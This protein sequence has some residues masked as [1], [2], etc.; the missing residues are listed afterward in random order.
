MDRDAL[1]TEIR[2]KLGYNTNLDASLII[3][4]IQNAQI[5]LERKSELPWFLESENSS[6]NT[7][8]GEERIPVPSDFLREI[9]ENAMWRYDATGDPDWVELGKTSVPEGRRTYAADDDASGKPLYYALQGNYFRLFPTPDDNY[10]IKL[11]Y[12]KKDTVLSSGATE[13]G[14]STVCPFLLIGRAGMLLTGNNKDQASMATFK[15]LY[16]EGLN[17]LF[18]SSEGREHAGQVYVRGDPD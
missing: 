13:N 9:N 17:D 5:I 3:G 16:E 14:W 7:T 11:I 10:T 8:A 15:E 18:R 6:I 4:A 2:N 1:E 12:Y